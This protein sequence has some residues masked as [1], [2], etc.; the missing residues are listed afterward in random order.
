[1]KRLFSLRAFSSALIFLLAALATPEVRA[2]NWQ[3]VTGQSFDAEFVRVEGTNGIF[4]VKGKDYPYP[5][6]RLTPADRLAIGRAVNQQ[7]VL[8]Q[9]GAPSL[10]GVTLK[11]GGATEVDI[12][13]TDPAQLGELQTAYGK[14]SN[15]VR[16][17]IAVPNDFAPLTKSYPL[18]VISASADG[19]GS[20]IAAARP[21]VADALARGFVVLAVDGEFGSPVA[22]D[23]TAFRWAL[24]SAALD[25]L[26]KEW[27][28]AASWPVATAGLR[29]G[30]GY[31]SEQ[32]AELAATQRQVVGVF[33]E[34]SAWSPANFLAQFARQLPARFRQTPIFLDANAAVKTNVEH[35]RATLVRNGFSN[36][37]FE[38]SSGSGDL[39]HAQLQSALAWFLAQSGKK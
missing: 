5:L 18:L 22:N 7:P 8:S 30:G 27:A 38:Q 19:S 1:M 23:S 3:T 32:A 13:V 9:T 34:D 37:R 12:A 2:R 28:Q 14:A 16:L 15:K 4:R 35:T 29:G 10:G 20:S 39:D 6:N 31:A 24:V 17:S 26:T 36:L 21:F 11:A 25:G 33:L